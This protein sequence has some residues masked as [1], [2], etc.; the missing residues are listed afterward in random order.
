MKKE[1]RKI[2]KTLVRTSLT[3]WFTY[4]IAKQCSSISQQSNFAY[5]KR[6]S[7][8]K[9]SY[10]KGEQIKYWIPATILTDFIV[11]LCLGG[12]W[13]LRSFFY[14]P[15]LAH[16]CRLMFLFWLAW[17]WSQSS[18]FWCSFSFVLGPYCLA[19]DFLSIF[20]VSEES[21]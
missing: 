7:K 6:A 8:P 16:C 18:F 12:I 1:K 19:L 3:S 20:I 5:T 10:K 14:Y 21:I 11:G 17:L 2:H 13:W 9:K 15:R 4:S